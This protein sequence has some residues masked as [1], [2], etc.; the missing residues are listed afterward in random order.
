MGVDILEMPQTLKGHWSIVGVGI[1]EMPQTLKGHWSIVG[2]G[3]LEMPQTL[4][5]HWYIIVFVKC[6]P[7]KVGGS[8]HFVGPD[9]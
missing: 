9:Q 1:L 8:I 5:G 2:V 4:K 6:V 7:H 3:V